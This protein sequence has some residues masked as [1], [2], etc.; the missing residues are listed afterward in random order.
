MVR[1]NLLPDRIR[2]A[3]KIALQQKK[4]GALIAVVVVILA[5][6]LMF[7]R[8]QTNQVRVQV[9]Q[10]QDEGAMV[11]MSIAEYDPYVELHAAI[12]THEELVVL[13]M[14][15]PPEW[16]T[17]L[18]RLGTDIPQHAWLTDL[19]IQAGP[20]GDEEGQGQVVM[21]G[22]TYSH[23]ATADWLDRLALID[24]LQDV[25]CRFSTQQQVDRYLLA[26]FELT[27]TLVPGE[28]FIP[29]DA[30]RGD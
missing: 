21:Q 11:A 28:S 25:L 22:F 1:I 27:A 23:P 14:G 7:V 20:H 9:Q 6:T 5:S 26:R 2:Q 19:R 18:R 4:I 8:H 16:T 17:V 24:Q 15:A 13:A 10:V 30:G 12:Q 29:L 3:R